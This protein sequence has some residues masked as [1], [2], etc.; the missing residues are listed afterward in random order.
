MDMNIEVIPPSKLSRAE[1]EACLAILDEGDAVDIE[2]ARDEI[3]RSMLV[4]VKK[5]R[6]KIVAVG[7]VKRSRPDYA[8]DKADRA[9]F[10]FDKSIHE[11]GYVA[12]CSSYRGHHLSS[13]IVDALLANFSSRPI[14]ATTSN[15]KM[16]TTLKHAGFDQKGKE[17]RSMRGSILSLWIKSVGQVNVAASQ[18][19][20]EA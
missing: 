3:P 11:L 16:M 13:A 10:A 8:A 19:T 6:A 12:V 17:W 18:P 20:P 2:Y 4:A 15:E 5:D 1:L 9:G 7:V 14:F